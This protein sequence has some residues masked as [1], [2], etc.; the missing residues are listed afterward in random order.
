M[1]FV[2]RICEKY[3]IKNSIVHNRLLYMAKNICNILS[4][5]D[6]PYMIG[7]GSLL[8]AV[9]HA[10]F[11]PWDDDFDIILFEDDYRNTIALLKKKL[12]CDLL[13]EDESTE[14]LFYHA[15]A[16]VRDRLTVVESYNLLDDSSLYKEKGLVVDLFCATKI[17][18]KNYYQFRQNEY[19]KFNKRKRLKGIVSAN[20][21]DDTVLVSEREM[22]CVESFTS[23]DIL[24]IPIGNGAFDFRDVFPLKRYLFEDVY[25]SG[26]KNADKILASIYGDYKVL[27]SID[28]IKA[29]FDGVRFIG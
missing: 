27:P 13:I 7:Y 18:K 1:I 29:R 21:L 23:S 5:Y 8:G 24:A 6:I 10:G 12:P 2:D 16:R 4:L 3:R 14:P 22:V 26:P 19:I 28:D 11:V 17:K 9:R 25:F 15:W 20:C